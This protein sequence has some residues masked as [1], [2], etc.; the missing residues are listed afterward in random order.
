[1]KKPRTLLLFRLVILFEILWGA[2]AWFTWW[3]D[4]SR[5]LQYIFYIFCAIAAYVYKRSVKLRISSSPYVIMAVASY[6]LGVMFCN[7][8]S[9]PSLASVVFI[10]YPILVVASDQEHVEGHLE[11]LAKG[12]AYIFIPGVIL[13]IVS[14][15]VFIPG[16]LIQK[17]QSTSYIFTNQIF[18]IVNIYGDRVSRF[19]S[20]FLEPGYLGAMLSFVLFALKYDFSKWY[21]K[22]LLLALLVSFSLTGY[23]VTLFGYTISLLTERRSLMRIVVFASIIIVAY[24]ISLVYNNGD[25]YINNRIIARLE[26]DEEKGIVGNNRIGEG[27]EF[28]YD[29]AIR[30]GDIW[31]GLGA[32][33]V[34]SINAGSSESGNYN[35]NIRGAGY[36][37]YF[38]TYGVISAL[39]FL[40]FYF[41]IAKAC[42]RRLSIIYSALSLVIIMFIP[43]SV[44]QSTSW[45]YPYILGILNHRLKR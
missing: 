8:F 30:D 5:L 25:N 10:L 44:P 9:L 43:Q 34:E 12:L 33:K 11:F 35:T 13:Y 1:M 3:I 15:F 28:Y 32:K 29:K 31:M 20:V 42:T 26:Y 14:Q 38:V 2:H 17:G 19:S 16:P 36:K 37:V 22:I 45:I 41:F 7:R 39:F 27:T 21:N 40:L 23:L 18:Q 4:E 6:A 24:N